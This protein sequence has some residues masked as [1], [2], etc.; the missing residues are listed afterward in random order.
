MADL[1]GRG[2]ETA[3]AESSLATGRALVLGGHA[4]VGKTRLAQ[5]IA[6]RWSGPTEWIS[7]AAGTSAIPFGAVVRLLVDTDSEPMP[8]PGGRELEVIRA[9]ITAART[10]PDRLLVVDDCH[11]LDE[12]SAL[13]VHQLVLDRSVP[14]LLTVRTGE[15][16]STTLSG[17]WSDRHAERVDVLP[18]SAQESRQLSADLL[19]GDIEDATAAALFE[20]SDGNPMLLGE[21]IRDAAESGALRLVGQ[22]W[23][24]DG[25][26]G[27][28]RQLR[29]AIS[30]RLASLGEPGRRVVSLLA[31]AEPLGVP[32]LQRLVP[33]IDLDDA[34]RRGLLKVRTEERRREARLGHPLLGE[35]LVAQA[36][37]LAS[38]RRELADAIATSGARRTGD[39]LVEARLRLD[40]GGTGADPALYLAAAVRALMLGAAKDAIELAEA[41]TA[42]GAPPIAELHRGEAL[43][44]EHRDAEA[45]EVLEGVLTRLETDWER[46]RAAQALQNLYYRAPNANALVAVLHDRIRDV[47]TDPVWRAVLEGNDI[48]FA[49]MTGRTRAATLRAEALLPLHD[50]PRVRLRLV[51]SVGSGRA[52]AGDLDAAF[53]F[54]AEMMPVALAHQVELPLAPAWVMNAQALALL[55]SGRLADASNLI[56]MLSGM[57][58]S[59]T[60]SDPTVDGDV[61]PPWIH[62]FSG[63]INLARGAAAVAAGE[64]RAAATGLGDDDIGGFF[65]WARSLEAEALALR[66]DLELAGIVAADAA[67]SRSRMFIYD[68]EAERARH[69]V[70]ALG[71][72]LTRA[73]DGLL[74]LAALQ[75][76][77]GQHA[78]EIYTLHDAVRLG[79]LADAGG[80]LLEAASHVDGAWSA[81][82]VTHVGALRSGRGADLIAA[83]EQFAAMH[84]NL[85]AAEAFADATR[86]FDSEALHS[87]SAAAARRRDECLGTCGPVSTPALRDMA[88]RVELT[89]RE[90]EVVELALQGATNKDIAERLFV[91]VRTAEGHLYRA[92]AKLG[93]A[94]RS[95][96]ARTF[97]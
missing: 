78:L 25:R 33:G 38:L 44:I 42:N 90:R 70:D 37:D 91:S 53:A 73:I 56:D 61:T 18:L 8:L 41:A 68:G 79:A 10:H 69:W 31:L 13:L 71:G 50:D 7:G 86:A 19:G 81:A 82:F 92:M 62:L 67:G 14:V 45:T 17:L 1:I 35:V 93:V 40:A 43:L 83:G 11:Q 48:Q 88:A 9:A 55:L 84:A 36:G 96:L 51:S 6:D 63:R 26:L 75:Q 27:H 39:V 89:R 85:H 46:V 64:L 32:L 24:W 72:E 57:S 52:L 94:D 65:R 54:V 21:L 12:L 4:G 47:V 97:A 60:I 5:E 76:I 23:R 34:E 2:Q 66:G 49:M 58:L 77:E 29:D 28:G 80:R 16:V 3:L 15:P 20:S 30:S 95:E 22:Q 59:G 87:R 74:H